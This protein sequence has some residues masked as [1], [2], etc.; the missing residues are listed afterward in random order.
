MTKQLYEEAL[1][2]VKKLKEVAEDNAKR[3][4]LEAVTPRIRDLIENQLLGE[5]AS[6][7]E[8]RDDDKLLMDMPAASVE[9]DFEELPLSPSTEIGASDSSAAA[10]SMPDEEGKVTLDLDALKAPGEEYELSFESANVVGS[11]IS[12]KK[13]KDVVSFA[14]S[15][16]KLS[17]DVRRLTNASKVVKESS[18]YMTTVS[19]AVKQVEELRTQLKEALKNV[20]NKGQYESLLESCYST[21]N[22]LMEQKMN[23]RNKSLLEGDVTL[24]LTGM[25]DELDLDSIGVDLITGDEEGDESGE[26]SGDEDLDLGGDEGEEG[27]DED[28]DLDDI[29]DEGEEDSEES[30]DSE[31]NK[32][33]S[34]RLSD[35][36]IV[37]IDEGMLRR[38]ISRMKALREAD[39]TKAQ[40]WGN[41]AGDVSDEFADDDMGDPFVDV[42]LTTESD[43]DSK[44]DKKAE[45]MDEMDEDEMDETDTVDE[46]D[47]VES[48]DEQDD[49]DEGDMDQAEDTREY[50]GN[51][52]AQGTG[53]G[54]GTNK[55]SRE[56]GHTVESIRRRLATEYNLQTEAKK[57]ATQA[58][59]K[60]SEAQ[61]KAQQAKKMQEKQQAKKQAK[62]MQEAYNFFATKFNESVTRSRKLRGML[63]EASARNGATLNGAPS[64]SA[65]ET[66][67]LRAK[68]AET[69][70]FNAKLLFTNKL[71]QN[72]S[73]TKRQK[74]E[75]IERL[76]EAKTEREV[77]LVYESVTKSLSAAAPRRMTESASPS[78]IGSASRPTRTASSNNLNEGF[79]AD[80][81]ARLAGIVK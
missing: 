19:S 10:I 40:S 11:I 5:D 18:E 70:L 34:R 33:E 81:W 73:L 71:L 56:A 77:K 58:K 13:S 43:D 42:E 60:Q 49:L 15:I 57:K 80:R 20:S 54:A 68:L 41:G 24:K 36:T 6:E 1:A 61:K 64:R 76:D 25:P 17:E 4:L 30:D 23:K 44:D 3:A 79:E 16:K 53:P 21:L 28:L 22:K 8:V 29:G 32:M 75:V 7:D 14:A 35:D 37:E 47:E 27:G 51:V 12:D 39:E 48:M 55:Q 52:A 67:V 31:E 50:G 62:K 65:E 63:A 59:K 9:E 45:S 66:S 2:D 26:E 69:N 74:A 38:E 46:M 72:E 78:V